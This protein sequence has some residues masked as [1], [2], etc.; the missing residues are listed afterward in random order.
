MA[1]NNRLHTHR[2][3]HS[4]SHEHEPF[5]KQTC[6]I[7]HSSTNRLTNRPKKSTRSGAIMR[8][9]ALD[10]IITRH[11]RHLRR[12][13]QTQVCGDHLMTDGRLHM[14]FA[15]GFGTINFVCRM[16]Q[17]CLYIVQPGTVQTILWTTSRYVSARNGIVL[18]VRNYYYYYYD[19]VEHDCYYDYDSLFCFRCRV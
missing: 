9:K 13:Q 4:V 14:L 19:I 10:I 2:H 7:L 11:A 16:T 17:V 3:V 1:I 18:R 8:L 15:D 5:R 6:A 12:R